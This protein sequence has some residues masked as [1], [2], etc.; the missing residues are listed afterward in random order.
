MVDLGI[1]IVTYNSRSYL[2]DCLR[3]ILSAPSAVSYEIIIVDNNSTDGTVD[4]VE[5][6]HPSVRLI[7]NPG[8]TGFAAANNLAIR[9]LQSRYVM[10]LNPDTVV[11]YDTLGA[12][13]QFMD[14]HPAAWAAGPQMLNGDG[15]LQR[16][17]VRFPSN[18][19][20]LVETFFLDRL[21]PNST[22]FGRH[23]EYYHDSAKPRKV[24][25]LQGSCLIVRS[26]AIHTIGGMD[27]N[28]FMYF[29][30]TDWCFR[31]KDAGGE[32]M[33]A[34]VGKVVHY[35][36]GEF[37]HYD[38]QRLVHYHRSLLLFYRKHYSI[39]SGLSL[40]LILVVRSVVRIILW[41]IMLL[42]KPGS[43]AQILS[44]VG[45]Y[46]GVLPML[47]KERV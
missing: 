27:E 14:S 19:N 40:R 46:I 11:Q 42:L 3:S 47:V 16:T 12:L 9:S 20:I 2:D 45:G 4:L 37:A 22:L 10:V 15:T 5:R 24:D 43:R 28:F 33:Y 25:Y 35:G 17:G 38:K 7:R 34:P 8:N 18:W 36:G 26:D 6:N 32:V 44:S 21:F 29:E 31:M 13:V 23:K 30:E 41:A 1:V 39:I